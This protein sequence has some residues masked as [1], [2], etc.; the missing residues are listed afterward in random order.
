[1]IGHI[2]QGQLHASGLVV[3]PGE[4]ILKA[5]ENAVLVIGEKHFG[6]IS[7]DER[8]PVTEG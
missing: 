7:R 3:E 5:T 4:G 6:L 1:V 2:H 8:S